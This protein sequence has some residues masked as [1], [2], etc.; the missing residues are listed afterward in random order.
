MVYMSSSAS[1]CYNQRLRCIRINFRRL[2]A[3]IFGTIII[4]FSCV[5]LSYC[6]IEEIMLLF[7]F[8]HYIE[9][10]SAVQYELVCSSLLFFPYQPPWLNIAFLPPLFIYFFS[11][12]PSQQVSGLGCLYSYFFTLLTPACSSA[13]DVAVVGGCCVVRLQ[14]PSLLL[15]CFLGLNLLLSFSVVPFLVILLWCFYF[16]LYFVVFVFSAAFVW[17]SQRASRRVAVYFMSMCFVRLFYAAYVRRRVRRCIRLH[18]Q[19]PL[20]A[21]VV[22]DRNDLFLFS[23]FS[24][25]RML[26]VLLDTFSIKLFLI[27]SARDAKFGTIVHFWNIFNSEIT[28]GILRGCFCK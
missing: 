1:R 5:K 20:L 3:N 9:P 16:S 22:S 11:L 12:S 18:L 7:P 15:A 26:S 19:S 4:Y 13:D 14:Q 17:C 28:Q 10:L 2:S 21:V 6:N 24:V 25:F 8:Y 23:M 27:L